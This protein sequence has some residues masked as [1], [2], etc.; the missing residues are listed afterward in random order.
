MRNVWHFRTAGAPTVAG[1]T[2]IGQ[3]VG[4]FY[5]GIG[6]QLANFITRGA[7]HH[8]VELAAVTQGNA[9][10]ADDDVSALLR[11]EF[12]QI[13]IAAGGANDLP[14]ETAITLS[15][16]GDQTDQKEE[17]GLI[18]PELGDVAG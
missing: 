8:R 9:G 3:A 16:Q 7:A 12:F 13:G 14:R 18:R 2:A 4:A 11:T 1:L 10:G 5:H 6:G 15:F 17:D